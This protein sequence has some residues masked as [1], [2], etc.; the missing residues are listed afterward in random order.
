[1]KD[2]PEEM[3]IEI[4]NAVKLASSSKNSVLGVYSNKG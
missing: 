1:M 2:V 3:L 4:L